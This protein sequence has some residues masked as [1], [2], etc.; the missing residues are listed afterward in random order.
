MNFKCCF[1]DAVM[2]MPYG[3]RGW[4]KIPI[5]N[6]KCYIFIITSYIVG[7]ICNVDAFYQLIRDD[8]TYALIAALGALV[9][10]TGAIYYSLKAVRVIV[11]E[12]LEKLK[13]TKQES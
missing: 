10:L 5:T 13:N 2:T 9:C 4:V 1:E 11:R 12:E 8:K 7:C 3:N 6:M